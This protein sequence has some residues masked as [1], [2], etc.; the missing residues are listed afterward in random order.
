VGHNQT[1][2]YFP[3]TW[4]NSVVHLG[5]NQTKGYF[6]VAWK[7]SRFQYGP[8]IYWH[9][10]G[11]WIIKESIKAVSILNKQQILIHNE[12]NVKI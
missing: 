1:I 2:G 7:Y 9:K 4:K 5:H 10:Q 8:S 6:P 3:V 12:V 11:L